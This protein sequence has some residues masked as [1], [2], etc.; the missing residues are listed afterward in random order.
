MVKLPIVSGK[1]LIKVAKKLD[2]ETKRIKGSHAIL[3]NKNNK[4][5][6]NTYADYKST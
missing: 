3:K 5:I 6:T 4:I 1:K 2:F